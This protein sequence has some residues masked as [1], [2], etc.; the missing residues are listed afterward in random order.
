VGEKKKDITTKQRL[1]HAA[2]DI[3][4]NEHS[5]YKQFSKGRT[6]SFQRQKTG[7]PWDFSMRTTE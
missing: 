6:L 7:N 4:L 5:K 3:I 1:G 2:A